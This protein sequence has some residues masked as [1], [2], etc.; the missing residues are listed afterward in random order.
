M[1]KA[2]AYKLYRLQG[3]RY[4]SLRNPLPR[5]P[6]KGMGGAL[7]YDKLLVGFMQEIEDTGKSVAWLHNEKIS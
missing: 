4:T 1:F 2:E 6:K 7:E 5:P 3:F